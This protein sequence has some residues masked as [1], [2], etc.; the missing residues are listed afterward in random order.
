MKRVHR[1]VG[2]LLAA[3]ILAE[4]SGAKSG[5]AGQG[6]APSTW[7][8]YPL[9]SFE[10]YSSEG[11]RIPALMLLPDDSEKR[12]PM[13]VALHGLTDRKESWIGLDNY[14][15]GGD[16][17][18]GLL[19][20]G[21]GVVAIDL[22]LHGE[23]LPEGEEDEQRQ[24]V[25]QRWGPFFEG[26]LADLRQVVDY[27]ESHERVD[28]SRI[29]LIGYSLGGMLGYAAANS[30]PRIRVL[31]TCVAPPQREMQHV[32]VAH[33]NV[34]RLI[35]TPV[36]MIGALQDE[37]Y[38]AEDMLWLYEKL[39]AKEKE[40]VTYDSGHSLPA[41]YAEVAAGW[42]LRYFKATE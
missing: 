34:D 22:R 19:A 18:L 36:L 29:G 5:G 13:V 21:C 33:R 16:V 14:S 38:P 11:Q 39:P 7:H 12:H 24:M 10:I 3:L 9:F 20:G 27:L 32:G 35:E 40:L 23:R 42:F 28:R 17:T 31:V 1:I 25:M 41:A 15:K 6:L 8:G 2:C 26:T 4:C 37:N 30:D